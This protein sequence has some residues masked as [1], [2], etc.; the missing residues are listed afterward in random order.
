MSHVENLKGLVWPGRGYNIHVTTF[1]ISRLECMMNLSVVSSEMWTQGMHT[2]DVRVE[3][4]I[5]QGMFL[6]GSV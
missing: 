1:S 4:T 2:G 3:I 6:E 5:E